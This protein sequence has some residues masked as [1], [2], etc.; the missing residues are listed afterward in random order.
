MLRSAARFSTHEG[1]VLGGGWMILLDA[2]LA[3]GASRRGVNVNVHR[4]RVKRLDNFE[5]SASLHARDTRS[6]ILVG[7]L[8]DLYK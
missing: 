4:A 8:R 5:I 1:G 3:N 7:F 2:I 6:W